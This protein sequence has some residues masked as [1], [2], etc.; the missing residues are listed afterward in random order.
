MANLP[1]L[2]NLTA[3]YGAAPSGNTGTAQG[4]SYGSTLPG[5]V[6]PSTP[7][8]NPANGVS[9]MQPSLTGAVNLNGVHTSGVLG[10][11]S[12]GSSPTNT[13]PGGDSRITQLQN[14]SR[15]GGLNPVQQT[16]LTGL[17]GQQDPYAAVRNDISSAWDSYLSGLGDTSNY[18]NDQSNAQRGIA[19]TQFTQ[20]QDLINNQKSQSLRDIANT[21]KNAFQAG[22][23]YLGSLGAGDSSAANQYSFAINQQAGKQTGDLNNFVNQQL[24][25][26]QGT[27]DTQINQIAQW[28]AQQQ[29]A[30][31]QQIASG[32]LQKGQDLSNLSKGILD[33]AIQATNQLKSNTQNQYNALVTWAANNSTNLGQLQSNIAGVSS[34][35]APGALQT[36]G[37]TGKPGSMA[38]YGGAPTNQKTDIF[39]NIIR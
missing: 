38:L 23:N 31:K 19:D 17:L 20:G 12:G 28:F 26:L 16:E 1:G 2:F 4:A 15:S 18:L 25:T 30:L 22:N 13:N 35:F 3:Q 14:M 6:Y 24:Q 39:G 29:E 10:A 9:N 27:H 7:T 11:S 34:A 32:Q 21:T 33:Q 37:G 8:P 5:A 36:S